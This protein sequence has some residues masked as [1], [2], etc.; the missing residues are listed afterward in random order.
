[1]FRPLDSL[2]ST[3]PVR[4]ALAGFSAAMLASLAACGS[5]DDTTAKPK[6]DTANQ[7][8]AADSAAGSDTEADTGG[9]QCGALPSCVD[10]KGLEDLS[11]CPKPVSEYECVQGCCVAKFIC[12][13]DSDCAGLLGTGACTSTDFTCA[14]DEA[15]GE[16][17][18]AQ[19]A[20][21]SE[22]PQGKV[23]LGGGCKDPLADSALT[24]RL[25]RP[26]WYARPGDQVDAAQELGLQARD[27]KGQVKP[28]VAVAWEIESGASVAIEAGKLKAGDTAGVTKIKATLNGQ[29]SN[30]A[31][32]VNLGAM[33]A[34][35]ALRVTLI[36]DFTL[37]PIAGP[38]QLIAVGM[39]NA[40]TPDAPIAAPLAEGATSIAALNFPADLHVV[41]PGYQQVS[42][43]RW[44]PDA[45]KKDGDLVIPLTRYQYADLE[46]D[47]KGVLQPSSKVVGGDLAYGG[48]DYPGEGEAALG[49]TALA[50]GNGLLSFSI[51]TILGPNVRRP[52]NPDA[53]TIVNPEPGKPQEIP[54]GVTFVFGKP[55]VDR[56]VLSSAAGVR[57]LWTLSG[58]LSL[59]ELTTQIGKIVGQVEGGL[60]IGKVVS[61]LLPYLAGFSSQI[62]EVTFGETVSDPL[63]DLGILKPVVPLLLKTE[64]V[65]AD[66]PK[67]GE[68][69]AE[70]VIIVGGAM[71]PIGEIVPLGLTAAA[72]TPGDNETPDGKA[73]ASADLPGLQNPYLSVGPLH[74]GL[75]VGPDN[76]VA[77]AAAI[78]TAGKGKKEAGSLILSDIGVPPAQWNTGAFL[79]LPEGSAYDKVTRTLTVKG[80]LEGQFYRTTLIGNEGRQ[81]LVYLPKAQGDVTVTLPDLTVHGAEVDLAATAKRALVAVFELRNQALGA[82]YPDLFE[83]GGLTHLL[84]S[85]KRTAFVDAAL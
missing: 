85:V 44:Q 36:D 83:P 29:A 32:L 6:P 80:Q 47:D 15:T 51:D 46:F 65:L 75:R 22:C 67:A 31:T 79:G 57:T 33:P 38:G 13:Q 69:W 19:C 72:D 61:I 66:L 76:H 5:D 78:V 55:V 48:I 70:A 82:H 42:I 68:G 7:T 63:Q 52:F 54:G 2:L 39:A 58:R 37:L 53:P 25:T 62:A 9:G 49:V 3:S 30:V 11:L 4:R 64:V 24:A 28:G 43:L 34:N 77:V 12:K 8:D 21:D 16:C 40:A 50:F 18:Q 17:V 27:S 41:V 59:A 56:F 20:K 1:M 45:A 23:C 81:W 60:N 35:T 10:D 73:D 14:C 84:Q 26:V 74:S 71:M